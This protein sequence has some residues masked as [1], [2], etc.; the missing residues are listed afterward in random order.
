MLELAIQRSFYN[1]DIKLRL[2]RLNEFIDYN[3]RSLELIKS[4][5]IKSV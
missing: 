2:V 4:L 1:F 5:D 3:E